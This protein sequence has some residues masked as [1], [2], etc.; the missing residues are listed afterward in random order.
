[1]A[2]SEQYRNGIDIKNAKAKDEAIFRGE[3]Y[4]ITILTDR[5]VRFEYNPTGNFYDN[6]TQLV[7]FRNFEVPKF[8]VKEDASFLQINTRY[9]SISYVKEKPFEGSKMV[10]SANLRVEL[11]NSEKSWFYKNPEVKN[12]KGVFVSFDYERETEKFYNG[13][14]SLD[15]FASFDDTYSFIFQEDGTLIERPE[16]YADIYVFL[17]DKDFDL[18][19]QDYMKLTGNPP[20]I[21]RYALGNWWCRDL[22]YTTDDILELVNNFEKEEIPLSI[23]LLDKKWH[24][25]NSTDTKKIESGFTFN[26]ELIA[27]PE[28]LIDILHEKNIRVGLSINPLEGIFP[29]EEHYK[30]FANKFGIT[31]DKPIAIDPTN[32]ILVDS[33]IDTFLHPLEDIGADFFFNDYNPSGKGILPLWCLNHYTFNDFTKNQSKRGMMLSRNAIV[34]SHRYPI[35]YSGKT[36][37]SWDTL[38][39]IPLYNQMASNIGVSF[40][41]HDVGG[42]F[43]GVEEE[44]LYT[45]YIELS[46]FSPIL[47][48][49]S[50]S[51]RY[52]RKEPW[53]WNIKTLKTSEQYLNLRHQL[54]PYLYTEAYNYSKT[55]KPLV[56][57]LYYKYPFVY[58]DKDFKNQYFFGDSLMV[59]PILTKQE[60]L[61]SRTMHR[62][63]IP[64][65]V[66]YD[67]MTGKKFPGNREYVSF[68][69]LEDY[70]VFASS[71]SIIPLSMGKDL[72]N[73][74]NPADLEIHV[75]PGKSNTF[76]LYEDDGVTSLYK[77]GYYLLTQIDYNYLPSNYTLIIRSLEGKSGIVPDFRN[78]KVRFRNTKK[79]QQ[80]VAYY[81][82]GMIKTISYVDGNDFVVE[83]SNVPTIG[84]ITINCKGKDI[85]I[86]AVRL[87][88]DEID[89]IL[90]DL[91]INTVLKEKISAIVFSDMPLKKKRIE[92][93][94]L[95]S[96][97]LTREYVKLFLRLL[98]YIGQI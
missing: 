1:M 62:F 49:H 34:A 30:E 17:Y 88:N 33:Y 37:I 90:L 95:K 51:G 84:Q 47:R 93:R 27:D 23:V 79:A 21:P 94:K 56:R 3:R 29:S 42:N 98:E 69:K 41:S 50:P 55:G 28:E 71:G 89:S 96:L 18:A 48:F 19:L 24:N 85:E 36:L 31:E 16:K 82:D 64:E 73:I 60:T 52:Y 25:D 22:P 57:P 75:F 7:M 54:I 14:Y 87:I 4:R 70:P 6:P 26:K 67:F 45:R 53:R 65:G 2:I 38:R 32:S 39:K 81:N 35:S 11:N 5:L 40:F 44:E 63:F 59:A 8:D 9:F 46:C 77:D 92:V 91:Q 80:V 12:Y 20:L 58:D 86:D 97:G 43:G 10:P 83:L 78:Y 61:I 74:S 66:W 68:Y 13:L 72:N 15:G 76:N